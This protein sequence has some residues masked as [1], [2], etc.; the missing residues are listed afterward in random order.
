V[1]L[2]AE[3]PIDIDPGFICQPNPAERLPIKGV[4]KPQFIFLMILPLS[5]GSS[6]KSLKRG[7][8]RT[9]ERLTD[10]GFMTARSALIVNWLSSG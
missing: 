6:V 5:A 7:E 8:E 10:R 2:R 9:N 3:S 4:K 1:S